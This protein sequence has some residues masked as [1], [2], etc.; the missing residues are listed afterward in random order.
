MAQTGA[1]ALGGDGGHVLTHQG[2]QQPHCHDTQ[3]HA[4]HFQDISR[5]S[6]GDAVVDHLGHQQRQ[7]QLEHRLRQLGRRAENAIDAVGFEKGS[8]RL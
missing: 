6:L 1:K 7:I 2:A 4:A 3:H 5:I 8:E